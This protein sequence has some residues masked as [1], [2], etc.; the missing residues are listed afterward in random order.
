MRKPEWS[1][2]K[3]IIVL[4]VCMICLGLGVR[5]YRASQ[6]VGHS[7]YRFN[8]A[9]INC[10][11]GVTFV[12]YDPTEKSILAIPFPTNLAITS[13]SSGEYAISA[14]YKLGS[15]NG[16]GGMFARQKVQGF[17]R[18]P[19]PGYLVI[20]KKAGN[21]KSMLN[22][23]LLSTVL[24]INDTSMSRLDA[25]VLLYRTNRYSWREVGE[26]ELVRAGVISN[27]TY[28]PERLQQYVGTRLFDWG[29]GAERITV[30]IFN[31]S[32]ENGLGS[33]LA[34]FLSNLGL[35]VVMVRSADNDQTL[36]TTEWQTADPKSA[37]KLG[38]IF[39]TLFGFNKPIPGNVPD[40]FRSQVLI[41][42]GKDAKELF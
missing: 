12:S 8:L 28:Y 40:E 23:A 11:A 37:D 7:Q 15:Y 30:A 26:S 33:D 20:N 42:V 22:G 34:D 4:V 2:A 35:D 32:G 10:E 21:S 27:N 17:M 29:I 9:V 14:L 1:F 36:D 31:E 39:Q 3:G 19:I 41:K 5:E 16:K 6:V 18:V 24:G 25:L 38:Y 13:R